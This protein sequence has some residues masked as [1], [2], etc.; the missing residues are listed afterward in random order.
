MEIITIPVLEDNFVYLI[1]QDNSS[2]ILVDAGD[3]EPIIRELEKRNLALNTIL[4]THHHADHIAGLSELN[5]K[6]PQAKIFAY[7]ADKKRIPLA[8]NFVED[9][10]V[11][12]ISNLELKVIHTPGHTLGHICYYLEKEKIIFTADTLFVSS[13]GRLFEGTAEQMFA[14]FRK[15]N[16]LPNKTLIYCGHEYTLSNLNFAL[17]VDPENPAIKEKLKWAKSQMEKNLST[18]PSTI[19]EEKTYNPFLRAKS[20]VEFSKLRSLKDRFS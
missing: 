5:N 9:N 7:G 2:A 16:E 1:V 4:I 17:S 12:K 20:A 19:G 6:F 13:C 15:L 8:T 3:A 11:I 18:V 10:Q 14:S